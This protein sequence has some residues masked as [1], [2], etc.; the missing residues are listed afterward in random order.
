MIACAYVYELCSR[1]DVA[2][3]TV[4]VPQCC[5]SAAKK[6]SNFLAHLSTLSIDGVEGRVVRNEEMTEKFRKHFSFSFDHGK[7]RFEPLC[8]VWNVDATEIF[9]RFASFRLHKT[10]FWVTRASR[11]SNIVDVSEINVP[12]GQSCC[13]HITHFHAKVLSIPH[14]SF[15]LPLKWPLSGPSVW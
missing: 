9:L 4:H 2:T 1:L 5:P 10:S 7:L 14:Y 15:H 6:D 8:I 12:I 13:L 3:V 11:F